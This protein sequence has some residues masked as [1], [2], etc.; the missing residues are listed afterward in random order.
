MNQIKSLEIDKVVT[1]Y[2]KAQVLFKHIQSLSLKEIILS[3]REA[4]CSNGLVFYQCTD[5]IENDTYLFSILAHESGQYFGCCHKI[6]LD[7]NCNLEKHR[8]LQALLLL[9]IPVF[10]EKIPV[11][12]NNV[13]SSEEYEFLMNELKYNPEIVINIHKQFNISTLADLPKNQYVSV[14]N[15]IHRIKRN[16]EDNE[17]RRK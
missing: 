2:V 6:I 9:N 10:D 17:R 5:V 13:I 4:L 7:E 14:L 8:I 3:T 12:Q 16:I 11:I 15:E 1:A